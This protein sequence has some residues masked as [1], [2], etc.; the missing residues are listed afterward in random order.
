METKFK[1]GD[2]VRFNGYTY[3]PEHAVRS[4]F[5]EGIKV[6][7]IVVIREQQAL[8]NSRQWFKFEGGEFWHS[9]ANFSLVCEGAPDLVV[10]IL[11]R[12]VDENS[13]LKALEELGYLWHSRNKPTEFSPT[14]NSSRILLLHPITKLIGTSG[15]H[16]G[17]DMSP[18][19]IINDVKFWKRENENILF[20]NTKPSVSQIVKNLK[21]I[22][23]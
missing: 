11:R 8:Y 4:G 1:L 7:D 13:V 18:S 2:I 17:E 20:L 10:V 6:G 9:D 22:L 3:D 23:K 15:T 14:L 21:N 19:E 5:D 12:P 16:G